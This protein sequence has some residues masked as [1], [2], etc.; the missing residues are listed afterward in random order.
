MYPQIRAEKGKIMKKNRVWM[1]WYAVVVFLTTGC[2]VTEALIVTGA[3]GGA[4][5]GTYAYINGGLQSDYKYSYDTVWSA[6]EKA[7]AEMR[8]LDVKP[9]KEIGQGRISATIND[10]KVRFDVQYKDRD[11]TTVTVRVG[12]LGNKISSQMLHDKISDNI[13]KE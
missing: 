7:M 3:A 9:A 6:C 13:V 11:V 2:G 8:A 10:K 5:G 1:F 4:G 12:W